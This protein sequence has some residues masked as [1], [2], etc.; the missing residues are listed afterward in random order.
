MLENQTES[1]S[2]NR[3]AAL[4][5]IAAL[6][7]VGAMAGSTPALMRDGAIALGDLGLRAFNAHYALKGGDMIAASFAVPRGKTGLDMVVLMPGKSGFGADL[8][9]KMRR[10]ARAGK[11]VIAPDFQATYAD[12]A[13]I[14]YEAM[15]RDVT[16]KVTRLGRSQLASG[17]MSIVAHA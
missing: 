7:A 9:A 16:D 11:L 6:S 12:H 15:V 5:G 1:V 14:G 8:A 10:Y 3:R 4:G 17:R 2:V 13:L